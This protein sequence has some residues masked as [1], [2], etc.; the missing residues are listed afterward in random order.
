MSVRARVLAVVAVAACAY[1]RPTISSDV[2][3]LPSDGTVEPDAASADAGAPCTSDGD[4]PSQVCGADGCVAPSAVRYVG[5]IG[6]DNG[7]CSQSEPCSTIA[8]ALEVH[9]TPAYVSIGFGSYPGSVMINPSMQLEPA[10][11]VWLVG[12]ELL[13]PVVIATDDGSNRDGVEVYRGAVH[14][15][16]LEVRGSPTSTASDAIWADVGTTVT[17]D[18]VVVTAARNDGLECNDCTLVV[19]RSTFRD[20]ARVGLRVVGGSAT[21]RSSQFRNN[22]GGAAELSG[23][24]CTVTSSLFFD[25]GNDTSAFGGASLACATHR[26]DGNTLA[27]NRATSAAFVGVRCLSGSSVVNRNN[28]FAHPSTAAGSCSYSYSLFASGMVLPSGTGNLIGNPGFTSSGD[29]H[30]TQTS[31]AHNNGTSAGIGAFETD[32]DG[33]LR[34]QGRIDIGADE[35][36]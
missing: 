24:D 12:S 19:D 28:L 33:E 23:D 25:N 13:R 8:R 29:Y 27:G 18:D 20:N 6:D 2:D 4:C 32:V 36:P 16:H 7:P 11:D 15:R 5:P 3:A 14:L 35:I 31:L 1:D 30:I 34:I 10:F 26:F 21:V 9:G 17:L 22:S